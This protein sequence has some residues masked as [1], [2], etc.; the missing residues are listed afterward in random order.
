MANAWSLV[1]STY[2]GTLIYS[3]ILGV[4]ES[5]DW[6]VCKNH[7][8][9][10]IDM[11]GTFGGTTVTVQGANNPLDPSST[12][13]KDV[14]L[15]VISVTSADIVQILPGAFQFRVVSTG[16]AGTALK[17]AAKLARP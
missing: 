16:G 1:H 2:Y 7:P 9:I 14:N 6:L 5:S 3:C 4:G 15:S 10:S 13:L 8:D 11:Y 12:S 17:I